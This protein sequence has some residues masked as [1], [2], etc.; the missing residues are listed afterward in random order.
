MNIGALSRITKIAVGLVAKHA[1]YVCCVYVCFLGMQI[2]DDGSEHP[3][4]YS[5]LMETR[6]L[7]QQPHMQAEW[8]SALSVRGV[9]AQVIISGSGKSRYVVS[10]PHRTASLHTCSISHLT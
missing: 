6:V 5:M 8:Q 4:R 10:A 7:G 3:H 1:F 9:Q 2:S